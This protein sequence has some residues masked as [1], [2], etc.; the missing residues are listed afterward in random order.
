[1]RSGNT[2]LG[3]LKKLTFKDFLRI[4]NLGLKGISEILARLKEYGH[5]IEVP[6][7]YKERLMS[8]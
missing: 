4:R 7:E 5:E 8:Y 3:D 1:M 2:T 6:E